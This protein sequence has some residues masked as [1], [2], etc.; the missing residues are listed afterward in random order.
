MKPPDRWTVPLCHD[1]H[2]EQ[3]QI[4][5]AAFDAKYGVDLRALAEELSGLSPFIANFANAAPLGGEAP[6]QSAG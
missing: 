3:H 2:H 5:H 6:Q 4:G 1:H